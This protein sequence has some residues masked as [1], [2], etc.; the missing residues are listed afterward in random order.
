M[1][2]RR[3]GC[4]RT[5]LPPRPP[6]RV[7][8]SPSRRFSVAVALQRS[9]A[10]ADAER[11]LR[12][13]RTEGFRP[14]RRSRGVSSISY[15]LARALLAQNRRAEAMPLVAQA[16]AEAPGDADVLA[17]SI[18]LGARQFATELDALHDPF[19]RDRALRS[20]GVSPDHAA[21]RPHSYKSALVR[22]ST[23]AVR[24][25]S[26]A[27]FVSPGF[28]ST[29]RHPSMTTCVLKPRCTASSALYFTQ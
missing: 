4:P 6:S 29:P 16:R 1:R 11:L 5:C 28:S 2:P 22:I 24:I 7:D 27:A 3:R 14:Y 21:G 23:P 19:T 10:N 20:A 12:D 15:Y 25:S 9:G 13:L 18:V 8:D 17:L 26:M